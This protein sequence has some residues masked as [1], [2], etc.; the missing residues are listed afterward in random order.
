MEGLD[1]VFPFS[2]P[3]EIVRDTVQRTVERPYSGHAGKFLAGMALKQLLGNES[4]LAMADDKD[5]C[6]L[7]EMVDL[8][9]EVSEICISLGSR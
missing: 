2:E 1:D 8:R 9:D 4:T 5:R 7:P 3:S 6:G